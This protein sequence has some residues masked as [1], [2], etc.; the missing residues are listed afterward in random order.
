MFIFKNGLPGE[1]VEYQI[2][3]SKRNYAKGT[4]LKIAEES[5]HRV[6]PPCP[7]S[8]DAAAAAFSIVTRKQN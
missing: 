2:T 7:I 1:N 4:V 6:T 3:V 8:D 5:P